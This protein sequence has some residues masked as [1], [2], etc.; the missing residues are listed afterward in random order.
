MGNSMD[1]RSIKFK[2]PLHSITFNVA[3]FAGALLAQGANSIPTQRSLLICDTT[4]G[5]PALRVKLTARY[6]L[7]I[8]RTTG[9]GGGEEEVE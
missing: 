9:A 3:Q 8:A 1:L 4:A 6:T 2:S 7:E 5:S